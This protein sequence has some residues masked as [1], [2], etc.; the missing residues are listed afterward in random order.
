[1]KV[2]LICKYCCIILL[3]AFLYSCRAVFYVPNSVN[4]PLFTQKGDFNVN[5]NLGAN[6][7]DLQ[8]A[9][10]P[11]N[12]IGVILNSSFADRSSDSSSNYHKHL[13]IESG[14]GYY[15][16]LGNNGRFEIFGGGGLSKVEGSYSYTELFTNNRITDRV[17][18]KYYRLFIQPSIGVN[19]TAF[20]G[21]F[22]LRAAYLQTSRLKINNKPNYLSSYLIE[23]VITLKGGVKRLKTCL[24]FGVSVP[25]DYNEDFRNRWLIL[26]LGISYQINFFD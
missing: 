20:Q 15:K 25:T 8:A 5:G 4:T 21:S 10:A 3:S 13:L 9:Y 22:S 7:Y 11:T 18:G 24:Q 1:M 16:T 26:N 17:N 19:T 23:P 6:G 12:E 14:V 2:N